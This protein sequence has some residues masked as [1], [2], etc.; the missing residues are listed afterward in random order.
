MNIL[1]AGGAGFIGYHLAKKLGEKHNIVIIDRKL[2]H[3]VSRSELWQHRNINLV[4][5][6]A[7]NSDIASSDSQ[8]DYR[9]TLKTTYILLEYCKVNG[10]HQFMFASSSAVFGRIEGKITEDLPFKP[11][12]FY[13]SAKAASEVLIMSYAFSHE[14]MP[15]I[16]RFP[17]VVGGHATHGVLYDLIRKHKANPERLEVLGTGNQRKPY[18]HVS[19]LID[20]MLYVYENVKEKI[21]I[22]NIA[23]IGTT[24][25]KEIAEMITDKEIVYTG[26]KAWQSDVEHY[27]YDT[28]KLR[29]LGWQPTM[30]SNEAV[31]RAIDEI[32]SEL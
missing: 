7:A 8:T 21:N 6:L 2:N 27:E 18:I 28:S 32:K 1:I 10:I 20:A 31:K 12:S 17:N 19:E 13:G 9:D 3:E 23:P 15:Y 4:I 11:I 16:F 30:T 14:I 29:H 24:S 26:G 25:V 22:Y 5:H